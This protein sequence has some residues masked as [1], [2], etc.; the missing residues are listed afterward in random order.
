MNARIAGD[1]QDFLAQVRK[2]AGVPVLVISAR[3]TEGQKIRLLD[4][5]ADDCLV[6]SA[7]GRAHAAAHRA[8]CGLPHQGAGRGLSDGRSLISCA[9]A[10]W[11]ESRK[12]LAMR[13][14]LSENARSPQPGR[15]DMTS[16]GLRLP[17]L[18]G[19]WFLTDGGIETVLIYQDGVELPEFAAFV[20]LQTEE[21]RDILR[22]YYRRYLDIA[23]AAPGAGFVL[24]SPTWRAGIDW[25][26]KLGFDAGAMQRINAEAVGLMS[27]LRTEYVGRIAGPVVISGCIGPRGDGYAAGAP[28]DPEDARR[29]HQL[30]AD[31]LAAAGVD[32]ITAVT[33]TSSA[34]AMGAARAAARAGCASAI[35]FTVETDGTLPS[36]ES[37]GAAIQAVDA[38]AEGSGHDAPAYYMMNCAHPAHFEAVVTSAGAWRDR[39]QG[40]RANASTLSHAELDVMTQLDSG[41]PQDLADRYR[42]LRAPLSRLN[43]LGGCCGTDHRHVA[44]ICQAWSAAR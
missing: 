34:E 2:Q 30:Q 13:V 41:N 3:E 22:R 35:S 4:A 9:R 10:G 21:G 36:G 39:I 18:D 44:A 19:G 27:E 12:G 37:L 8:R 1:G 42:R 23:A 40:L 7:A 28:M 31:A 43:V 17:Q 32:Q 16:S 33:M 14:P 20:L 6:G 11:T 26:A 29:A 24:E 38:D 5:G 15:T 25:G